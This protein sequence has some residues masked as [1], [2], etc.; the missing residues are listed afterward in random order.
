LRGICNFEI[1]RKTK[2]KISEKG[3]FP[4]DFAEFQ[5][6]SWHKYEKVMQ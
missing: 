4:S 5:I 2:V 3:T 1:Q 6:F